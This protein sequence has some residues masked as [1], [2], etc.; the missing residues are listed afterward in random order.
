MTTPD[1]RSRAI[2][3]AGCLLI[4]LN[5]NAEVPLRIRR[6]ANGIARH[7]PTVEELEGLA[8][9]KAWD[10]GGMFEMPD[11]HKA[12]LDG[13]LGSPLT[14]TARLRWPEEEWGGDRST[15]ESETGEVRGEEAVDVRI[16]RFAI[17]RQRLAEESKALFNELLKAHPT[18]AALIS[19]VGWDEQ[20]AA[21]WTCQQSFDEKTR[22]VAELLHE[23]RGEEALEKLRRFLGG[24]PA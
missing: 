17:A 3:W 19:Q 10:G 16:E 7:F 9:L 23:G 5:N 24:F 2:Y 6:A 20:T 13:A 15:A 8:L 4:H 12:W 14:Y 18:F 22:S 21:R 1:E 11:D